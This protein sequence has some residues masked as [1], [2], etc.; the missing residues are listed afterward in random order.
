MKILIA[1][2]ILFSSSS[3]AEIYNCKITAFNN[4][5]VESMTYNALIDTG[6]DDLSSLALIDIE[7]GE[8]KDFIVEI[9]S[10]GKIYF[11]KPSPFSINENV[12]FTFYV[13]EDQ[14]N[15]YNGFFFEKVTNYPKIISIIEYENPTEVIIYDTF[16]LIGGV[17]KGICE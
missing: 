1:I 17:H 2:I 5:Q 4:D 9:F 13:T 11:E 14:G 10:V 8:F 7:T 16:D 15:Y 3:F 6:D 12:D